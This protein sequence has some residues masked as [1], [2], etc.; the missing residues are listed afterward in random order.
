MP[1]GTVHLSVRTALAG[2]FVIAYKKAPLSRAA[3]RSSCT[4]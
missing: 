3:R 1:G 2:L 4:L